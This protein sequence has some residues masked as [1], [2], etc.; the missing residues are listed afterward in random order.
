MSFNLFVNCIVAPAKKLKLP[1][2]GF[3]FLCLSPGIEPKGSCAKLAEV[4]MWPIPP[5]E[6]KGARR[7][8]GGNLHSRPDCQKL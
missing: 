2:G 6:P 1:T 7:Y 4:A 8:H 5:Y 3:Y